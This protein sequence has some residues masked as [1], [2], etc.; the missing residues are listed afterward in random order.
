MRWV[1][2]LWECD[3]KA[4]TS[5]KLHIGIIKYWWLFLFCFSPAVLVETWNSTPTER[6][7]NFKGRPIPSNWLEGKFFSKGNSWMRR[8]GEEK[9]AAPY[10]SF[11]SWR[12]K[13]ELPI[14]CFPGSGSQLLSILM[15]V[16][17]NSNWLAT[18]VTVLCLLSLSINH[19]SLKAANHNGC[20]GKR[21]ERKTATQWSH[22]REEFC[23]W[24]VFYFRRITSSST[25]YYVLQ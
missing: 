6:N 1:A 13:R 20:G 22:L 11:S 17:R 5:R 23:F 3:I 10:A 14:I 12:Q 25:P 9:M 2:L 24:S 19:I 4:P 7:C 15:F 16:K 18:W 21:Y 8:R